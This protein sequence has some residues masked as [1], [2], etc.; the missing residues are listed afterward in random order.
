M[1]IYNFQTLNLAHNS[2]TVIPRCLA[3]LAP[4]LGRISFAYNALTKMGAVTS[5]PVVSKKKTN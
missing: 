1:Q 5:Y 3:C 2:F 4:S